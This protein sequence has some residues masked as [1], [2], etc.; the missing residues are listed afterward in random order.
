MLYIVE[1]LAFVM[2]SIVKLFK[3]VNTRIQ[4]TNWLRNSSGLSFVFS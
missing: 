3:N 1:R 2:M 4:A